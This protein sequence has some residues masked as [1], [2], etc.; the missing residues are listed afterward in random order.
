M[1]A[2][3]LG[4]THTT[5][6]SMCHTQ[7]D[8]TAFPCYTVA[9]ACCWHSQGLLCH[10]LVGA[11]SRSFS[12]SLCAD[13]CTVSCP[14]CL[15]ACELAWPV[16][17][18]TAHPCW[19]EFATLV[20]HSAQLYLCANS[21]YLCVCPGRYSSCSASVD[22]KLPQTH[23]DTFLAQLDCVLTRALWPALLCPGYGAGLAC[24][25]C[26]LHTAPPC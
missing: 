19:H 1:Q 5:Q 10:P 26:V 18:H 24:V 2:H 16:C 7:T 3:W 4:V 22:E 9:A 14:A 20:K 8:R 23:V 15:L 21:P 12:W 25:L 6:H 13:T 11:H 17:P